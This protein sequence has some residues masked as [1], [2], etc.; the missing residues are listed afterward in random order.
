MT[1]EEKRE[2][3]RRELGQYKQAQE[4]IK[5]YQ[6][7]VEALRTRLGNQGIDSERVKVQSQSKG[8]EEL[9]AALCDNLIYI[10]SKQL[11]AELL[12]QALEVK[13]DKVEDPLQRRILR[14][15]WL[16]NICFT[17]IARRE[18]YS[19]SYIIEVHSNA[20]ESFGGL[21]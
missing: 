5:L 3:A 2:K 20:L 4:D 1:G 19:Y 14:S 21:T 8:S 7:R 18:N 9:L 10:E 13:I 11:E 17:D 6:A 16:Y 12:C 15:F